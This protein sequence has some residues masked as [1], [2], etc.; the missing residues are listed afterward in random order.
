MSDADGPDEIVEAALHSIR[1][2][3]QELDPGKP[4]GLVT[5]VTTLHQELETLTDLAVDVQRRHGMSWTQIGR[6]LGTTKQAA[7]QRFGT[8]RAD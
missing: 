8:S 1:A 6:E 2:H 5:R 7:Q 4:E 3:L